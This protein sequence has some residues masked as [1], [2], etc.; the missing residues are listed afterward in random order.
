V[1]E[2]SS[3]DSSSVSVDV[4]SPFAK[5]DEDRFDGLEEASFEP[6][7]R[8]R[9]RVDTP[10]VARDPSPPPPPRLF[11][12]REGEAWVNKLFIAVLT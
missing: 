7:L 5:R 1:S 10:L 8:P 11:P 6:P 4:S 3:E 12:R 9:A 2:T